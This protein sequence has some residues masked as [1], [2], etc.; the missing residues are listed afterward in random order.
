MWRSGCASVLGTEG[1]VFKSHHPDSF[2]L[3]FDI[4]LKDKKMNNIFFI[5]FKPS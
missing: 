2:F 3:F 1:H 5:L 4:L